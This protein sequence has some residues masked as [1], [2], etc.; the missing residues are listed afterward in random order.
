MHI[1]TA[2]PTATRVDLA[3]W[4]RSLQQGRP[5]T[6]SLALVDA[7]SLLAGGEFN[8]H[9]TSDDLS[10]GEALCNFTEMLY[11]DPFA[12]YRKEQQEYYAMRT[13]GAEG[14]IDAAIA[15]CQADEAGLV[16]HQGMA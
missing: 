12:A 11:V 9:L 4:L 7:D 3:R 8:F 10:S 2:K 15:Y 6:L 1:V 14:D 5:T 16:N 13:R